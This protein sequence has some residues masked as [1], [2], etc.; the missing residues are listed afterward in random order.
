VRE[1][2]YYVESYAKKPIIIFHII[3]RSFKN[4]RTN[5]KI[6]RSMRLSILPVLYVERN[7]YDLIPS[8][9]RRLKNK[10]LGLF[11]VPPKYLNILFMILGR[12]HRGKLFKR[13]PRAQY[14]DVNA[15]LRAPVLFYS[16][17]MAN[18]DTVDKFYLY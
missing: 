1:Y 4:C 8:I 5:S 10:I 2:R 3:F 11:E 15:E 6:F 17:L 9:F 7:T 13:I 16:I 18:P 14:A 12:I